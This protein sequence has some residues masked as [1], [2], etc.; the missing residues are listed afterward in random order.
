MAAE[1]QPEKIKLLET[2]LNEH[3]VVYI[4]FGNVS[5]WSKRLGWEIDLRRLKDLLDS[6]GVIQAR[7]YFG[8]TPNHDGSARFMTFVHKT[9]YK[10]RTKPVKAIQVSVDVSSISEKSPDI[11]N[12]FIKDQLLEQLNN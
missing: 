8:T 5:G 11:L 6:F 4:D 7:F 10:V 3:T 2:L 12:N 1:K 9:G